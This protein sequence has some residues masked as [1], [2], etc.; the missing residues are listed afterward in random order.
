MK[1][2]DIRHI[3]EQATVCDC[4]ADEGYVK[5]HHGSMPDIDSDFNAD[6]RDEVKAYLERRYNKNG[7]QR[8]FSAGTFTT[9]RIRSVI[10]DVARTH[11]IPQSVTNYLTAIIDDKLDWTGLMKLAF[12]EKRVRDFIQKHPDV[13]EEILPIMGQPRAAGIHASAIIITPE[14]VK[15]EKVEC[16]DLL[17][18]RKMGDLLVSE[19]S[20]VDID[21]IGILKNDV[22]GVRELTRLS[23]IIE[24]V[25]KE[26]GKK[27]SI[28]EIATKYLGDKKVFD[29]LCKGHT[30]GLFQVSG[31]GMTKFIKRLQPDCI[32][33]L[34]ASV[35]IYRPGPLNS[36]ATDNYI[37]AKHGEF[38]P[39][40]LWG[41]YD[42]LNETYG[43]MIY[44][45]EIS[46][47]AQKVGSLS[48]GDSVGLVKA[49]SKKK[50]EKVRKYKEKF[51]SGSKA[52]GCPKEAAEQIWANVED[53]AKYSFNKS[54]ATAYGL[55]AYVGAWLKVYYPTVF[56]TVTLRDQKE[57]AMAVLMNEIQN[58]EG[59][60]LRN[61]DINIS[62]SNFTADLA[63]NRIYW[64]LSRIKQLGP[65]AVDYIVKERDL[66]GHFADME[67]FIKRIFK[68]RFKSFS[69]DGSEAIRERC[70]VTARSIRNLIF[71][72]AFDECEHVGSVLE[73]YGLMEKAAALLG[74]GV[75]EKDVPDDM[76]DK[77]YFWSAKQIEVSSHGAIDYQGI[78]DSTERTAAK[79]Y[80]FVD[81]SDMDNLFVEMTKGIVCATI[82]SATDKSFKDKRTGEKKHF[83]KI[84]LQQNTETNILTIWDDWPYVKKELGKAVG[85][86]IVTAANIRWSDYDEKNVFQINRMLFYK[87][88]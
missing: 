27:Y 60:E 66:Y 88:I 73:R 56:Y 87:L 71:A 78:F 24:L 84:E 35:A 61:P 44:Q 5:R 62:D 55:T 51:F 33:D 31:N 10:K 45:E 76:R 37:R 21:T 32:H 2:T 74:F 18:I 26:Y 7:M 52:N 25:Y 58:T 15:G 50:L 49:L 79:N 17:P 80:K 68:A 57:E 48:L 30:Q 42:I 67:D 85:R 63:N 69:D 46:Q 70:P 53:A 23:D 39:T 36:G 47:V 13:F 3:T 59:T 4:Y 9:E 20:G 29:I 82:T 34:I 64:S 16:F 65:K 75:T 22:L 41:T 77:H 43:E 72:G 28:L 86:I 19:I 14:I 8:V 6:R 54:H 1:I 12:S 83:G 81:F 40:Y 11:R 38:E